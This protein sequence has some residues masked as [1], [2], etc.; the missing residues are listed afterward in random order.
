MLIVFDTEFT[1][2][3]GGELL[4]IGLVADDDREFYVE[5]IDPARHSRASDFCVELVLSQF[6]LVSGAAVF[7]DHEAGTRL[8]DWLASFQGDLDVGSDYKLDRHFFEYILKAAGRWDELSPRIR[9]VDVADL[10]SND[11]ALEAQAAYFERS[12][13][14]MRHHSLV[15]AYALRARW[16][17]RKP[18]AGVLD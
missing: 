17:A 10:A 18:L 6:G 11:E 4:S 5:V 13:L 3:K 15:D 9:H 12:G 14:L 16:R 1:Q 8:A 7:S 2:F